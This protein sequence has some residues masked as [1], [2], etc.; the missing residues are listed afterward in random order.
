MPESAQKVLSELTNAGLLSSDE[1]T[2][3][4]DVIAVGVEALLERLVEEKR[5]TQYQARKFLAGE[6][7]DI[8]FGDYVVMEE[9][10]KGGMGTVLLAK[11]RRMDREVAIKVLPVKALESQDS[12]A[13]FFQEVKVAAQLTHPNIVHAYDAGE[14]H[15]FHY[16]VME[17]VR[18]H[19]LAHVLDQ[20][21]PIPPHL[22]LDYIQQAAK[23][24][25]YAHRKGIVHRDIKP[26]NL[27]LDDEGVVKI[28]DMGLARLGQSG[29]GGHEVSRHLTTTG[30]VMGTVE[31]M[32]PE[33]A[34]DT[35]AADA[36]SDIY[37][38]GCTLYRLVTGVA[39]FARDTVVKTILAHREA[40]LPR[41]SAAPIPGLA[42]IDGLFLKMCAKNPDDRIQSATKLIQEIKRLTESVDFERACQVIDFDIEV[43]QQGS[44]PSDFPT[45]LKSDPL[46]DDIDYTT[47]V[48]STPS[49]DPLAAGGSTAGMLPGLALTDQSSANNPFA[50]PEHPSSPTQQ[51]VIGK[52]HRGGL[53]LAIGICSI[54]LSAVY[55]VG[56]PLQIVTWV[57]AKSDLKEMNKGIRDP[58]GR[59]MT[60]IGRI[61]AMIGFVIS[62]IVAIVSIFN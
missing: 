1:V 12:V 38:L 8:Y 17:Y 34:E 14:H 62:V 31:Y 16:L 49:A 43:V 57:M 51:Y 39:P 22:A 59:A 40:P 18:G 10:G 3:Y 23:G 41:M 55:F 24:L 32:S 26:S 45:A 25:E 50:A 37:S 54:I 7:S 60:R 9:L 42:P 48:I 47:D 11:H 35:R 4:D 29:V 30:Q 20:L 46:V 61:L 13:R 6:S 33:Q 28:L 5:I 56:V 44:S 2:K 36:R 27:L 19:D 21:G 15:G 53:I 58:D 52:A